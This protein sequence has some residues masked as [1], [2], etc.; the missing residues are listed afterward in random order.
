MLLGYEAVTENLGHGCDPEGE[1][2]RSGR[3]SVA[4]SVRRTWRYATTSVAYSYR[5]FQIFIVPIEQLS[6]EEIVKHNALAS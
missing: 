6:V 2:V 4:K 5:R 3:R 1:A